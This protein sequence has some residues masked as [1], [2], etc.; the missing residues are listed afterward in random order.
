[1]EKVARFF[2]VWTESGEKN[3]D[4]R[5]LHLEPSNGLHVGE[6]SRENSEIPPKFYSLNNGL[7]NEVG[8]AEGDLD[9]WEL[10]SSI[11]A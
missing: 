9:L 4:L 8:L 6:C 3:T 7:I 1:M 11:C 10:L 2:D 5:D